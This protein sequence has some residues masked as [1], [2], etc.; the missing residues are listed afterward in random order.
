MGNC[1]PSP[2]LAQSNIHHIFINSYQALL[3]SDYTCLLQ[4]H[5]SM[6]NELATSTQ[7]GIKI[8]VVF[9][10]NTI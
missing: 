3:T 10:E 9:Q 5:G 2:L 6:P 7:S 8:V 1:F 4:L